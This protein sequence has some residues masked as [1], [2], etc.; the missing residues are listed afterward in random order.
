[1]GAPAYRW[2]AALPVTCAL[3]S[4]HDGLEHTVPSVGAV[5]IAGTKR[6]SFQ[7]T[8]LV[9]HEEG[10]IAGAG[11]VAVPDAVLL[12]AVSRTDARI[13]VEH[14]ASRRTANLR[15][16]RI[17]AAAA[18]TGV[19][20]VFAQ[21]AGRFR[22]FGDLEDLATK[23]AFAA[24]FSWD[25][26]HKVPASRLMPDSM[27]LT[28]YRGRCWRKRNRSLCSG[29]GTLLGPSGT[30]AVSGPASAAHFRFVVARRRFRQVPRRQVAAEFLPASDRSIT[31]RASLHDTEWTLAIAIF[32]V[33]L[34]VF[35]FLFD[36]RAAMIPSVAVLVSIV[37]TFGAMYLMNFSLNNLSL[38]ALTIA[39][40]F[41]V[42]DAI[43]VLENISRHA[44]AG[45]GRVE[46]ALTGAREVG[47]TVLSIS[48]S[49]IAVFIPILLMG[50]IVGRLFREFALTL[51]LAILVSLALSLTL[52]PMMS[53]ILR[54]CSAHE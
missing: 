5:N 4:R 48:L 35:S 31:I 41:V 2:V 8:E 36:I 50:G 16:A 24:G 51:S 33:T 27:F 9:E 7:I 32:L 37:G 53:P 40:G 28:L 45:R 21:F 30:S 17:D 49:L 26:K 52:T 1:M 43:V 19:K 18:G 11:I 3:I 25:C 47:F 54:S 46:A 34:I 39:T 29:Y 23:A 42:D 13:H 38:M 10:M 44:D 6:T 14:D 22:Q 20:T 15:S 12:F